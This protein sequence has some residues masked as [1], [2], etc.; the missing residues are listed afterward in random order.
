M[1][2]WKKKNGLLTKARELMFFFKI[3]R[4]TATCSL[5]AALNQWN[6]TP[7]AKSKAFVIWLGD[8]RVGSGQ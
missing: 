4:E 2:A 3:N 6:M 8:L 5:S 1:P 7:L